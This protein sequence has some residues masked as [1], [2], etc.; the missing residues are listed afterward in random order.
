MTPREAPVEG[1]F[2]LCQTWS[3]RA[4]HWEMANNQTAKVS[5]VSHTSGLENLCK[6]NLRR[7]NLTETF[8]ILRVWYLAFLE[9]LSGNHSG[10]VGWSESKLACNDGSANILTDL[11]QQFNGLETREFP[12]RVSTEVRRFSKYSKSFV[13]DESSQRIFFLS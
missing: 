2:V 6:L 1:R 12:S 10:W 4:R 8:W 3:K 13:D 9:C 5:H 11:R 7:E